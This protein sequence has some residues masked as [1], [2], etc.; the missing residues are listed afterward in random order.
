MSGGRSSKSTQG[1]R[2]TT[3]SIPGSG[4]ATVV[5]PLPFAMPDLNY[6]VAATVEEATA[7]DTLRVRKVVVL[8]T[9]SV[10]VLVANQDTL[11]PRT[12]TVHLLVLAD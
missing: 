1:V 2:A 11:T 10:S 12:G 9:S 7:T 3:G 6:T 5:V 4:S 8:T